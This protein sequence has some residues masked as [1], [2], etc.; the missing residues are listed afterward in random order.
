MAMVGRRDLIL[1][2][3]GLGA[4]ASGGAL[5]GRSDL[6]PEL[7]GDWVRDRAAD[8]FADL[9]ALRR[10]GGIYLRAHPQERSRTRL[11]H[12]LIATD[13]GTIASRLVSAVARDWQYHQV[14]VVDGWLLARAEAR[15]CALLHLAEGASA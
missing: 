1:A 12:L 6:R 7:L 14:V 11:S 15:L 13:N 9:P 2:L 10:L 5:R 3:I 8:F 4:G